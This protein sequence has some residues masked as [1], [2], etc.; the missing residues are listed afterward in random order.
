VT[1][2]TRSSSVLGTALP[3]LMGLNVQAIAPPA[4]HAYTGTVNVTIDVQPS[5]TYDK[6]VCRAEAAA[7]SSGSAGI[8]C[9]KLFC[10]ELLKF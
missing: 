1:I 3:L 4:A 6:L 9:H 10:S 8:N 2:N 7:R 5:K